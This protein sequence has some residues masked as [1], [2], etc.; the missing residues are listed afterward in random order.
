MLLLKIQDTK[1]LQDREKPDIIP[2]MTT[3]NAESHFNYG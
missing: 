3:G 2:N 1:Y